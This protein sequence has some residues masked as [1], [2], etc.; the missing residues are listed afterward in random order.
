MRRFWLDEIERVVRYKEPKTR[1]RFQFG[2]K[3]EGHA[4]D[5]DDYAALG[6]AMHPPPTQE[7][8]AAAFR[9]QVLRFHPDRALQDSSLTSEEQASCKA[10][11]QRVMDAHGRI[12]R[13]L[14][15]PGG[16]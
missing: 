12:R 6:L 1:W 8:V 11:F 14:A 10:N 2:Q 7:A 3:S 13:K 9:E 5:A 4:D 15:G 16:T